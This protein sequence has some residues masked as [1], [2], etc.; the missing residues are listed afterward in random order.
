[1]PQI[2]LTEEQARLVAQAATGVEVRDPQ[3]QV[4]GFLKPYEPGE[5]EIIAECKRRLA[6]PGPRIPGT[7]V[8]AMMQKLQE[9][10]DKG[11][12]TPERVQEIVRRTKAGEPL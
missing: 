5:A 1:M 3:G 11:E 12:V 9:L 4:L 8:T 6:Q 10:H 7:R 2:V